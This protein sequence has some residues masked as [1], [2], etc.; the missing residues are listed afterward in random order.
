[1]TPRITVAIACYQAS[2]TID[3]A[4][5]SALAQDW[6]DFEVLVVDDASSD[7]SAAR[8]AMRM[9]EE[10][11]LRLIR[12]GENAGPGAVRQTLLGAANGTYIAFFDDDDTSAPQRLRRQFE[13]LTRYL[14]R[15]GAAEA[16]CYASGSR[17]YPNGYVL[18]LPAIGSRPKVP[19]GEAVADYLLFNRRQPGLFY[20]S[21]TPTCALF[22]AVETLVAAGGFD[23]GQRRVEDAELAV[24]LARRG[25]HF[26]GCPERLFTQHATQ[27]GDKSPL[28]NF[29]AELRLI[30]KNR[31]YLEQR[32]RYDY[33]RRWARLRYDHFRRN[34]GAMI[35]DLAGLAVRHPIATLRHLAQSA[36]R[37]WRH[38][39]RMAGASG[40]GSSDH[41]G[42][43]CVV[44]V[45]SEDWYFWSHRRPMAE[46]VQAMGYHVV[47][48]TRLAG[49]EG[50]IA[51]CGFEAVHAPFDRSSLNPLRELRTVM[52]LRR[53]LVRRRP[54]VVFAVALKPI[55]DCGLAALLAGRPPVLNVFA[56]MGS[57]LGGGGRL[58]PVIGRTIRILT[59]LTNAHTV[60]QNTDDRDHVLTHGLA[61]P[62]AVTVI[63]GSGIDLNAFPVRPEPEGTVVALMVS[64]LLADKGVYELVAAAERL[65]DEKLD[66]QVW[67]A[68]E[69]DTANPRSVPSETLRNWQKTG[70]VTFLGR[71]DDVADLWAQAHIAVLPSYREGLPK[72]LLE[73]AASGR[74]LVTT[75]VTGCRD[76]VP[77]GRTGI[78]VARGDPDALADALTTL[79]QDR[80]RRRQCG[81]AARRLV[82]SHY[83]STRVAAATRELVERIVIAPGERKVN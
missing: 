28:K 57:V 54:V 12:H 66:V 35:R 6:P 4:V 23:P 65:R 16:V 10:P 19:V 76:L 78:L 81:A 62:G 61:R 45:V 73:A 7:D 70:A 82:E 48:A 40:T 63:P 42:P 53:V 37:R 8:V 38:E 47:V 56:G 32:G 14:E 50:N 49:H 5:E 2:E 18:D 27:A 55:V 64:R 51:A 36:G 43:G 20:G 9:G 77:E 41:R 34:R 17:V 83:S 75:D 13:T 11:R 25:A 67:V 26:V 52:V 30:E 59:A 39:R 15:T 22:A 58:G 80:T 60:V 44:F 46:A 68:G 3:R 79:A 24:R 29:E 33:A 21:G 1:M 72:S 31:D 74:P 71:R 69:P